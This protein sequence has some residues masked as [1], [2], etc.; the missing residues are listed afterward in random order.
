MERRVDVIATFNTDGKLRPLWLQIPSCE[1]SKPLKVLE[2]S[3]AIHEPTFGLY[4]TFVCQIINRAGN[5]QEVKL[6]L[7]KRDF[8]W[9][10]ICNNSAPL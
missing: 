1:E 7:H 4:M 5:K 9:E 2:A 6:R 8:Y 10:V 3:R